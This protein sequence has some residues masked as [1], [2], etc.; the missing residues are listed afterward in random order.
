MLQPK[1]RLKT[2]RDFKKVLKMGRSFYSPNIK[3]KL[4]KNNL[5]QSRFGFIIGTKISKKSTIRNR[6]KRQAREIIR[7]KIKSG[8]VGPGF[9]VIVSLGAGLIGKKYK[10]IKNELLSL[11]ARA[12]LL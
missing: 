12:G 4:F 11:L 5:P 6:L 10:E 2:D 1:N 8:A 9:D 7:L 3:L